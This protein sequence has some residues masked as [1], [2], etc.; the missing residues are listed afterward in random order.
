MK[1]LDVILTVSSIIPDLNIH[2][3]FTRYRSG[4]WFGSQQRQNKELH[5]Y[6]FELR[7]WIYVLSCLGGNGVH[8][9]GNIRCSYPLPW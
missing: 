3:F 4:C 8:C 5:Q 6:V 9:S 1:S 7:A 2:A